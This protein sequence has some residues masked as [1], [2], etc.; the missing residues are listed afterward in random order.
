MNTHYIHPRNKNPP[1]QGNNFPTQTEQQYSNTQGSGVYNHILYPNAPTKYQGLGVGTC[2]FHPEVN[3][4]LDYID[5][6][7]GYISVV[8]YFIR[9]NGM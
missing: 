6:F 9:V 4:L 2:N 5:D 8:F 7:L 1:Q 3:L